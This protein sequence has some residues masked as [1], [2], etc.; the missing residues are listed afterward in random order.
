[1]RC[2]KCGVENAGGAVFC[3]GCGSRLGEAAVPGAEAAAVEPEVVPEA[4]PEGG[5]APDA[6]PEG[7]PSTGPTTLARVLSTA[8]NRRGPILMALFIVLMM[9][10]V[11]ASWA[12]LKLDV[13]GFQIVSNSYT[14]WGMFIPRILFFL[15]IIPLLISLMMIAGIGTRR[16]VVETHICTF[17]GGVI[18][19]VWIIIFS[20]SQVISTLIK[21]VRVLEVNVAGAQVATIFFFVGFI[22]GVILTSYDRG[23]A[24]E[25]ASMGG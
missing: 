1:M 3:R 10:M 4:A 11:F 5:V 25:D 6:A 17:V 23:K 9:A 8:W 20:L 2:E 22:V 18:F 21:N 24:L 7:A 16:R 14:G 12:F 19:T 13:L 15:S